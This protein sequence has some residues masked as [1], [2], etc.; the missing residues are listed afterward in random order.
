MNVIDIQN[1]S[2]I[3]EKREILRDISWRVEAG[4]RYFILGA[5]GAG[6]TTLVRMLLGYLWP[7]Y[8]AKISVLGETY[9]NV[10]LQELRKRIAWVSPFVHQWTQN[11]KLTGEELVVS[12]L[13]S[14]I[15]MF[16]DITSEEH[17]RAQAL[18]ELLHAGYL[19][20]LKVRTMS[21]G[22]QVKVL[23]ARALISNP[24]LMILDEPNVFLDIRGREFLLGTIRDLAE[25]RP[26]LTILFITQRTEDILPIF[27]HGMILKQGQILADGLREDVL[28]EENLCR[29]YDM[30]LRLI[31]TDAGRMY[32]IPTSAPKVDI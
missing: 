29:A 26:D 17:A 4:A 19:M 31:P 12:G 14:S 9:G 2:V 10:N 15:G 23:I 24:E 16:R 3:F 1:A 32:L 7:R 22:E 13:D 27:T 25:S 6:K 20:T 8:G 5:N 18:L 28:T 11:P 21:S 30:N